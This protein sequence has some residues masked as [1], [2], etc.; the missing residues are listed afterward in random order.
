MM[1]KFE[2]Q[3]YAPDSSNV[4]KIIVESTD[5]GAAAE[6]VMAMFNIPREKIYAVNFAY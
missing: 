6:I 2:V 5:L 3:Y 1:Q 4:S